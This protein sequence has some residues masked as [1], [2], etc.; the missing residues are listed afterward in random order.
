MTA[1]PQFATMENILCHFLTMTT[2]Q[3][4]EPC[5]PVAGAAQ[6]QVPEASMGLSRGRAALVG[7]FLLLLFLSQLL[8]SLQVSTVPS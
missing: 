7:R 8:C 5:G 2:V 3:L 1:A 4:Q 6:G